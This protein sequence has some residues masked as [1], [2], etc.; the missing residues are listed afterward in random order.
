[1]N[2]NNSGNSGGNNSGQGGNVL[3]TKSVIA[4]IDK[5][6]SGDY[7]PKKINKSIQLPMNKNSKDY[8]QLKAEIVS[9]I[10]DGMCELEYFHMDYAMEHIET[11]LYY[12]RHIQE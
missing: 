3:L 5:F 2:N 8:K 1:M 6:S 11:A 10:E 7:I 12:L 9:N 4:D